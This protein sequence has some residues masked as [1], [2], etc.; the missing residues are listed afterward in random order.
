MSVVAQ[1]E[2]SSPWTPEQLTSYLRFQLSQMR[3][4]NRHHAFEDLCRDFARQNILA[5]ILPATGPVAAGGDQGRDFETFHTYLANNLGPTGYFIGI[6]PEETVVFTCTLQVDDIKSKI[7]GDV[8]SICGQGTP[9]DR[10]FSFVEV[11]V[12]TSKRHDLI[13][14]VSREHRV[15]LE[16]ID[17]TALAEILTQERNVWI[18]IQYLHVP[19]SHIPS[20]VSGP[21]WYESE[22][23]RLQ[24]SGNASQTYGDL[25]T[26]RACMKYARSNEELRS[27]LEFWIKHA[28]RFLSQSFPQ[29]MQD[30]A[31]YEIAVAR[32]RGQG[33]MSAADGLV[34]SF[35]ERS[36][37][38]SEP[39][40]LENAAVLLMYVQGAWLHGSTHIGKQWIVD[41]LERLLQHVN[42]L[43]AAETDPGRLCELLDTKATLL[44]G[45]DLAAVAGENPPSERYLPVP[46]LPHSHIVDLLSQGQIVLRDDVSLLSPEGAL[47]TWLEL[48]KILPQAP[49]FP[50]TPLAD[51]ISIRAASFVD[52][53]GW[54]ALTRQLDEHIERQ[55]GLSARAESAWRRAR[56]LLNADRPLAAIPDLEIAR[57]N[58]LTGDNFEKSV[59]ALG[60]T[61]EAFKSLGLF[62][63]AKHYF[64]AAGALASSRD[65]M[66]P[67]T[68]AS[69]LDAA[70]CDFLAGN[71]CSFLT[72][73]GPGL[74]SHAEVRGDAENV[75]R[76][77]DFKSALGCL[78]YVRETSHIIAS[79][80]INAYME[81]SLGRYLGL[82]ASDFADVS[83]VALVSETD[84][85]SMEQTL[86]ADIGQ[87]AFADSGPFRTITW[88]CQGVN[89]KV[90][91]KNRRIDVLAAERFAAAAQEMCTLFFDVDLVL[92][93]SSVL[94]EI[95]TVPSVAGE[96]AQMEPRRLKPTAKGEKRWGIKLTRDEGPYAYDYLAVHAEL[97]GNIMSVLSEVSLLS[98]EKLS[99]A[100]AKAVTRES[101]SRIMPHIRYDRAASFIDDESFNGAARRRV[102]P[103]G[104]AGYSEPMIDADILGVN[105]AG[106]GYSDT[107]AEIRCAN[108]YREFARM[109][110][111]TLARL[112]QEPE[113]QEVVARL[114]EE[115]WKD[116]HILQ[117][118]ANL[119]I[120]YRNKFTEETI[121]QATPEVLFAD[122]DPSWEVIPPETLTVDRLK[123]GL[124]FS[125]AATLRTWGLMPRSRMRP[126]QFVSLLASRY[127][128]WS[129]DVP[130]DDPFRV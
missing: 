95:S 6:A 76:W 106:P 105:K 43:I 98:D 42:C 66:A 64:L 38:Y 97:A 122:E 58:W 118:L 56:S 35:L 11:D 86:H 129:S 75:E 44:C 80:E 7:I 108:R 52:L 30:I 25:E 48:L 3:A 114:H 36:L 85:V 31:S 26:L 121:S 61:A 40:K 67:S 113:F 46:P 55:A 78:T 49:L 9:V 127:N 19:T 99:E 47:Q 27:D 102:H 65:I 23:S 1:P 2:S 41:Y 128:Y 13:A 93:P 34:R 4:H 79:P 100:I 70:M 73:L 28:S 123:E 63:A 115:G 91:C 96:P 82:E 68:P 72:L 88:K 39:S 77:D 32:L 90:R 51:H 120:N 10:I 116:W 84:T 33:D 125:Y 74:N 60:T 22:K 59:V 112:N 87:P 104:K 94:V 130:H 62:Y 45:T 110:P 20:Q 83:S 126:E 37:A 16:I 5:N 119:V 14:K 103:W 69:L 17:G 54:S 107:E 29:D 24:A 89:W 53:Q 101:L 8:T 15:T 109:L 18:A 117:A 50:V 81:R 12:P 111:H 71:W 57:K 124:E 21:D 92:C